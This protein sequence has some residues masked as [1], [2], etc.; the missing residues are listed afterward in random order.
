MNINYY[1]DKGFDFLCELEPSDMY[2]QGIAL[3]C[4]RKIKDNRE[5]YS[6]PGVYLRYM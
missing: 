3:K 2:T 5:L 1:T 6:Q 4:V